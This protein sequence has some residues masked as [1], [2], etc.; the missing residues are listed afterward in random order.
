M[1]Q[2]GRTTIFNVVNKTRVYKQFKKIQVKKISIKKN[3][4]SKNIL[5]KLQKIFPNSLQTNLTSNFVQAVACFWLQLREGRRNAIIE[6]VKIC[7][8]YPGSR[9][10]VSYII[11]LRFLQT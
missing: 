8:K 5:K 10:N 4:S 3:S 11:M 1:K 7:I 6:R 2:K 9:L